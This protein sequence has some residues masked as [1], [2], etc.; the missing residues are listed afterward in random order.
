MKSFGAPMSRILSVLTLLILPLAL[1]R[2]KAESISAGS[3]C[4]ST[5]VYVG[6]S[7]PLTC[8]SGGAQASTAASFSAFGNTVTFSFVETGSLKSLSGSSAYFQTWADIPISWS[9]LGPNRPIVEVSTLSLD[10]YQ[11]NASAGTFGQFD[12]VAGHRT[13]I[14]TLL[15]GGAQ[16]IDDIFGTPGTTTTTGSSEQLSNPGGIIELGLV[17]SI[18]SGEAYGSVNLSWTDQFFEA[19]GVTPAAVSGI[20]VSLDPTSVPEPSSLLL[21]VPGI[22][23]ICCFATRRRFSTHLFFQDPR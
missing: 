14:Q 2:V 7:A 18:T 6:D 1:I 16:G 3:V 15:T 23:A 11:V 22:I 12:Y 4:Q 9:L 21:V 8:S 5:T 19:D 17:G 13:Q 10:S 20:P